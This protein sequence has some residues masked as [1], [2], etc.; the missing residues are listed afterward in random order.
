[1]TVVTSF[2]VSLL[3]LMAAPAG[4]DVTEV[5][6]PVIPPPYGLFYDYFSKVLDLALAKTAPQYGPYRLTAVDLKANNP[7]LNKLLE[8]GE[9]INVL[10]ASPNRERHERLRAVNIPLD[11]GLLGYRVMMIR[12]QDA[13]RFAAVRQVE[14]LKRIRIGQGHDWEDAHILAAAGFDLE[15]PSDFTTLFDMLAGGRFLGFPRAIYEIG[16]E[17]EHYM[18]QGHQGIE[19]E[20]TVMIHYPSTRI[21]YVNRNNEALARR[22]ETGLRMAIT[23][24]SFDRLFHHHPMVVR[25]LT[26]ANFRHR[27]I[28]EVANP[29]LPPDFPLS[30]PTLWF[31]PEK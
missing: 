26:V 29:R 28:F 19:A 25:A 12:S 4:A 10:L 9:A 20:R 13:E 18:A 7:R 22:L 27:R 1:M 11:K 21:A 14:D 8:D 30:D 31:V 15:R 3:C 2:F 24:G 6:Y 23:D 5:R 17:I 16:P